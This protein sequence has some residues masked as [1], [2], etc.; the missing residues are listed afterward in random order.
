MPASSA[1]VSPREQAMPKKTITGVD[2]NNKR[3]L[4]RVDFNVPI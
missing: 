4:T 2:V 3:V 1:G